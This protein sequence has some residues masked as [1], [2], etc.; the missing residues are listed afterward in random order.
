MEFYDFPLNVI[1]PTDKLHFSE[2]LK[3]P[4][5]SINVKH[6]WILNGNRDTICGVL[7]IF[8]RE[9]NRTKWRMFPA[10]WFFL[11]EGNRTLLEMPSWWLLISH[12]FDGHSMTGTRLEYF[13]LVAVAHPSTWGVQF[14]SFVQRTS[15]L[16]GYIPE[17]CGAVAAI[18]VLDDLYGQEYV[19][20]RLYGHMIWW[21]NGF[22]SR[23]SIKSQTIFSQS[24]ITSD[25]SGE[26]CR[27]NSPNVGFPIWSQFNQ[28]F[29]LNFHISH[30]LIPKF[31]IR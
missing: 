11:A 14:Q 21:F 13:V 12:L 5:R 19:E 6:N 20:N 25:F 17:K 18:K 23:R 16:W 31:I 15:Q 22:S 27:F 10:M 29:A 26:K 9:K 7:V 3:P 2:G 8:Q 24:S 4:S 30:I 1:I 28:H